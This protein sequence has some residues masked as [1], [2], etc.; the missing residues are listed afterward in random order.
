MWLLTFIRIIVVDLD[1]ALVPAG[2]YCSNIPLVVGVPSFIVD[3]LH[4]GAHLKHAIGALRREA[5]VPF[6]ASPKGHS[7][8]TFGALLASD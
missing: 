6:F 3:G 7:G 4:A 1:V 5:F 2:H 8:N